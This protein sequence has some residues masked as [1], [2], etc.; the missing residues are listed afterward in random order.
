MALILTASGEVTFGAGVPESDVSVGAA[1]RQPP[2]EWRVGDA[3]E[4]LAARLR[5]TLVSHQSSVHRF[6]SEAMACVHLCKGVHVFGPTVHA[7]WR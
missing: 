6:A 4:H 2:A 3:V 5:N 7:Y 1:G